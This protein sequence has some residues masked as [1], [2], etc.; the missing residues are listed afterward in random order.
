MRARSRGEECP[1]TCSCASTGSRSA[2]CCRRGGALGAHHPAEL[3]L[4]ATRRSIEVNF[5]FHDALMEGLSAEYQRERER[6]VRGAE[7]LRRETITSIL[8]EAPVDTDG[9]G[10]VLGYDLRRHH[11]GLVLW[12]VPTPD[13]PHVLPRLERAAHRRLGAPRGGPPADAVGR[14]Q[15]DVGVARALT[16]RCRAS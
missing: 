14:R 3:L 2:C 4:A 15:H 6:W 10:R 1:S 5:Q 13:D 8:A 7:A 16:A 9:A 12:A 11:I